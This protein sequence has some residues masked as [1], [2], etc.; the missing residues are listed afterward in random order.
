MPRSLLA[1]ALACH[2]LLAV[3][4]AWC[5]PSF[6]GPDENSHYEY[7]QHLANAKTLPLSPALATARG[8]P[9]TE[10]V[11]LVM[12]PPL[13]YALLGAALVATG[14]DDTVFGPIVNPAFGDPN[15]P[16]RHLHFVHGQGPA[17]LL[18]GLRLVSVLLGALSIVLVHRL[19]RA[20]CPGEPRVAGLAA[21]LVACLPM[22]SF[23]HGVLHNDVLAAVLCTAC[24][25][26]LVRC[27]QAPQLATRHAV[28][29]G[30][31]LGLALLTKLTTLYLLPLAF[32]ALA[33]VVSRER[34]EG[35][36]G[37]LLGKLAI[38]V[39]IAVAIALAIAGW[40]YARNTLLYGDP[41]AL[42]AH[43]QLFPP[44]PPELRWPYLL[45]KEP[46]PDAVP[47]FL[48]TVFTS[49][50]GCFGWFSLPPHPALVGAGAGVAAVALL[51]LLRRL[52]DRDRVFAERTFWILLIAVALV[53]AAAAQ[54]N[55]KTPQPQAR[56][57]FP[58]IGPASV[59]L[60]AGLVRASAALPHRRWL[61]W[62]LPITA[63]VVFFAWFRPAFAIELAPAPAWHRSLVGGI[64]G[65]ES[66]PTIAL[67]PLGPHPRETP[68]LLRWTDPGAPAGT[69]Y[70]FY[71]FAGSGRV[72][73][74]THEW[75]HGEFV[76]QGN[77]AALPAAAWQ[78]LPPGVDL[79]GKLRRVP[80][81]ASEEP[82]RLP[83]SAPVP[84]RRD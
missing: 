25:L 36:L 29:F 27:V 42:S 50:F 67:Q 57:L 66:P 62:L 2:A 20:C 61:L 28:A 18:F 81:T 37:A 6:E 3:G 58:A 59:L 17:R 14:T 9:Q 4:Y 79:F 82:A 22:W 23:L 19:G 53:F 75:T 56:F 43:E 46:W 12:H 60:A 51:G 80:A 39:A 31:L 83:A 74:A 8:L 70:S 55:W 11:V 40:W 84:L 63:G 5:T 54:F 44:L 41:L 21:L 45:G 38:A 52:F 33:L 7:A 16:G 24:T 32:A 1:F 72:W 48:P 68:P 78:F 73:L 35:R 64:I 30:A 65:G 47:S 71:V 34:S 69:R 13:Y 15:A 10:S 26:A 49:L 76:L 77:E